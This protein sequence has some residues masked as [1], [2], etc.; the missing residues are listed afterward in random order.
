MIESP[1]HRKSHSCL[2]LCESLLCWE[3]SYCRPPSS[4]KAFFCK[5]DSWMESTC[6]LYNQ[7]FGSLQVEICFLNFCTLNM[8]WVYSLFTFFCQAVIG[9]CGIVGCSVGCS[10][11]PSCDHATAPGRS[12]IRFWG[13]SSIFLIGCFTWICTCEEGVGRRVGGAWDDSSLEARYW[14]RTLC[15]VYSSP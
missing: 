13:S 10:R 9:F 6:I 5:N 15:R 1:F 3:G 11:C 14:I 7:E 8:T 2:P 4:S 12:R